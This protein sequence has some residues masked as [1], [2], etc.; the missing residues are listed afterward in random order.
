MIL[1]LITFMCRRTFP[2]R[3]AHS[4]TQTKAHCCGQDQ[5][6]RR[7]I[8]CNQPAIGPP[9]GASPDCAG[10]RAAVDGRSSRASNACAQR[11][12]SEGALADLQQVAVAWL[13]HQLAVDDFLAVDP[14]R[15]LLDHPVADG[16]TRH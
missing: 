7:R 3:G 5:V 16:R 2:T 13:Q 11:H 8:I 15:A 6:W 1:F 9:I 10:Y 14:H 4:S 12:R